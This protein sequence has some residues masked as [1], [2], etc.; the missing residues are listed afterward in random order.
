MS[1]FSTKEPEF[2]HF[3]VREYFKFGS[4]DQVLKHYRFSLPISQAGYQRLL[5]KYGV[6]KA[7]GANSRISETILFF[8]HFL[9][10]AA[11][12]EVVYKKMPLSFQTSLK[13]IYRVYSYMKQGLTRRVGVALI[14]SPFDNPQK[15]L[16]AKDIS[17]PSFNLGKKYGSL[18]LP[19]GYSRKRDSRRVGIIRVLQQEV[20]TNL[21]VKGDFPFSIVSFSIE[22][23]MYLDIA[24]IRVAVYT[25]S[26]PKELSCLSKFSSFKLK[27]YSFFDIKEILE[28]K[29]ELRAGIK[30]V[31]FGYARY[32]N[33][34]RRKMVVN[35]IQ[36]SSILNKK[37]MSLS[38]DLEV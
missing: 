20:F 17:T 8:E 22:P 2:S 21:V 26:L 3:L 30:E 29:L 33:I 4:V 14:I 28:G 10:D 12:L 13:T 37:L 9:K 34:L 19:M 7:A 35:P 1:S 11:N 32:L 25:L 23:F 5:D 36:D 31:I 24:D 6:I 16:L 27:D 18:S 15:I 38:I